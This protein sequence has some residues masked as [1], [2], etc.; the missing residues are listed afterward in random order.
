MSITFK[1]HSVLSLGRCPLKENN[2]HCNL[3]FWHL[4]SNYLLFPMT[5]NVDS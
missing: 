3:E 4:K 1:G 5:D 2:L